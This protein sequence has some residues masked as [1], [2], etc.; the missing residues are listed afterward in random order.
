VVA[1][2]RAAREA[3]KIDYFPDEETRE[4][5]RVEREAYSTASTAR[6]AADRAARAAKKADD[7]AARAAKVPDPAQRSITRSRG[8][9]VAPCPPPLSQAKREARPPPPPT[10][11]EKGPR[12]RQPKRE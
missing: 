7:A 3:V 8:R 2:A 5:H 11:P 4:A 1:A 12:Q 10:F 6:K 9:D